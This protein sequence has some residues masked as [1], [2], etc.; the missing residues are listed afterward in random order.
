[1][2]FSLTLNQVKDFDLAAAAA[3]DHD[4]WFWLLVVGGG[5]NQV[6]NSFVSKSVR[7]SSCLLL[8]IKKVKHFYTTNYI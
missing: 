5:T 2:F 7:P 3:D 6:A 1:M 4:E 8:L